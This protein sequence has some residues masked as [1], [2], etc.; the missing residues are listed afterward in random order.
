MGNSR[1]KRRSIKTSNSI[2]EGLP[3]DWMAS[4]AERTLR[5]VNNTSSTKTTFLPSNSTS[6]LVMLGCK[7]AS[8]RRKSSLKKVMSKVPWAKSLTPEDSNMPTNWCI[9]WMPLL[10]KPMITVFLKSPWFSISCWAN[11]LRVISILRAFRS[12]FLF[13]AFNASKVL[14]M[15]KALI[16]NFVPF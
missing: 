13:I 1:L 4:I 2:S 5:P 10:C 6:I 7:G 9:T 3:K 16:E 15:A 14:I 8:L 12:F 11:R